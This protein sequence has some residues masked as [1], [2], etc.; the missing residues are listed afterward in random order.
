MHA[1]GGVG[2]A[3]R[4]SGGGLQKAWRKE[5]DMCPVATIPFF[6]QDPCNPHVTHIC[7]VLST[8]VSGTA[9]TRTHAMHLLFSEGTGSTDRTCVEKSLHVFSLYC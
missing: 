5:S 1:R 2:G 4:G 8:D 3:A 9:C 6:K 7:H